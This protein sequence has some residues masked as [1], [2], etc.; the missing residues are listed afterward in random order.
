[1]WNDSPE[2]KLEKL[3]RA[4]MIEAAIIRYLESLE[5]IIIH[6]GKSSGVQKYG[7]R[8][9]YQKSVRSF[10][11]PLPDLEVFWPYCGTRLVPKGLPP[12]FF[13]DAKEKDRTTFFRKKQRW[14]SG[15]DRWCKEAYCDA[16]RLTQTPTWVFHLVEEATVKEM[17]AQHVPP[18]HRVPPSGLFVHPVLLPI[19]DSHKD[20]KRDMVY[21]AIKDMK[22]LA[23]LDQVLPKDKAL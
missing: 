21:W 15:I 1:M 2:K 17:D 11:M 20:D 10:P 3:E 4:W 12:R 16:E 18:Q 6:R 9:Y 22:K 13:G 5:F 14:Q 7:P 23:E 19:A 8:F